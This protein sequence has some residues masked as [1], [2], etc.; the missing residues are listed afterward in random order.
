[1]ARIKIKDLPKDMKISKSDMRKITGGAAI[2]TGIDYEEQLRWLEEQINP[3][4]TLS[5]ISD[6][7]KSE[8]TTSSNTKTDN[9]K[10]DPL[11]ATKPY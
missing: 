11:E 6:S 1:M 9:T 5:M 10:T 3:K 7:Y 4:V 8:S 2:S